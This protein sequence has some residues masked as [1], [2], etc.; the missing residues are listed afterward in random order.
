MYDPKL[1]LFVDDHG[2]LSS[3]NVERI[4]ERPKKHGEP[5]VRQD[6]PWES[7]WVMAWGSVFKNP[8][9][10][11]LQM[12]YE[13]MGHDNTPYVIRTCY[14]ESSDGI[15]WN[16]PD[17]GCY[18][19]N[20]ME[21]TNIVLAASGTHKGTKPGSESSW[22]HAN[23]KHLNKGPALHE[24]VSHYDGTNVVYDW[25]EPD[26]GKRYKWIGCMWRSD[27]T[28]GRHNH[29]LLTSP[30]G[31]HWNM[32]P[33]KLQ[34]KVNDGTKVHW[35]P[36]RKKWM[37]T[38]LTSKV[39]DTGENVRSLAL[40][41]SDDLRNW[42]KMDPPFELDEA[43]GYGRI[44]Q[45]H[46]LMPFAYGD[47]YIGFASMIH[48]K[49]GWCQS[50]LTS[51][52]DGRKYERLLRRDPFLATGSGEDFDADSAEIAVG[53]PILIGDYL[54]IYY[55]GRARRYW[56]GAAC[57]GAIGLLTIKRDR[58]AGLANGGWF[59]RNCNNNVSN[60]GEIITMPVEVT[61]PKLYINAKTRSVDP[62]GAVR[63]ELLD[64]NMN[65]IPGY[66][67]EE[68]VPYRGD[69]IRGLMRWNNGSSVEKLLRQK[70][71]VRFSLNMA[72]IYAYIFE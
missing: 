43:D 35:D 6:R 68:S 24:H 33:E 22:N 9:T 71:S 7:P 70:V 66:T 50:Y 5:V 41:E 15:R 47:Q 21:S 65:P 39:L 14:A 16:K 3:K 49:E 53:E 36:V 59:N 58:F 17:L 8:E 44:L 11:K 23:I 67:L 13:S 72:T 31:H 30:D 46:F 10:A 54:Y 1:H 25:N 26:P 51:S 27:E 55:C 4:M 19:Y 62:W 57:T 18:S 34:V 52:R 45:G 42:S 29:N 12:W 37:L 32:I 69:E 2:M 56:A 28:N 40:A 61:G 60:D 48:T 20:G 38:F 63:T 64:E